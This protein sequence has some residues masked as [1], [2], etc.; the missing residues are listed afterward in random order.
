M[1]TFSHHQL[2]LGLDR[3]EA[4]REAGHAVPGVR[5]PDDSSLLR[6]WARCVK[7]GLQAGDSV[8]F[9]PVSRSQLIE[10]AERHRE[11]AE[12]ARPHLEALRNSVAGAGCMVLMTNPRGAVID[13]LGRAELVPREL[14]NASRVGINFD[15]RC[16]GSSAPSMAMIDRQPS[17]V[18]G[19]AHYCTNLRKFFC[20]AAPIEGPQGELLGAIDI[21]S[22]DNVPRFDVMSLVVETATEIENSLYKAAAEHMLLRFQARPDWIETPRQGILM[23][24]SDGRIMGANRV[25]S[26]L[27]GQSRHELLTSSFRELFDLDP[28]RLFARRGSPSTDVSEW[29]TPAGLTICGRLDYGSGPRTSDLELV[30]LETEK[31]DGATARPT[32]TV[33]STLASM[34]LKQLEMS[35]IEQALDRLD[36]NVTAVARLLGISRNTI[37]RRMAS[38][39]RPPSD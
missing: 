33:T 31:V 17:L 13:R 39:T 32:E 34:K 22:Y 2:G 18:N 21:S 1:T 16:I 19:D 25:A 12:A 4:I 15:E 6:A 26:S 23:V 11:L 7:A 27:L 38:A 14:D 5:A 3:I 20:V 10:L 35:A 8:R 28:N 37:Y 9:E 29:I 24:R 36:G 30:A